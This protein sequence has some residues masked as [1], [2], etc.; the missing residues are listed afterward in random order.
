MLCQVDIE[1]SQHSVTDRH[2]CPADDE[3]TGQ[4]TRQEPGLEEV[5]FTDQWGSN[6]VGVDE[7]GGHHEN[8]GDDSDSEAD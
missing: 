6:V 8:S 4:H 7:G 3:A 1:L 2:S 5:S